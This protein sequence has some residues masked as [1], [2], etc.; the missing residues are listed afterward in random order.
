MVGASADLPAARGRDGS[1]PSRLL[2]AAIFLPCLWLIVR[3]GDYHFVLLVDIILVT[4]VL[5]FY[6]LLRNKG[7]RPVRAVGVACVLILSW[8]AYFRAGVYSNFLLALAL[9]FLMTFELLRGSVE[10]AVVRIASTIFGVL[11]V[12][13]LGSHFILLREL[14]RLAGLDYEMGARFVFLAFLLTWSCD[15]GAYAIGRLF[16][17]HS[18]FPSVSPKKS[19]E[20]AL[21][22]I[23]FAVIAGWVAQV[24][25][26]DYLT[27]PMAVG[28]AVVAAVAGI[29]GDLVESLMKR[30]SQ[31]KDSGSFIPG[32]GGT[33]DRFDS[34]FFSIPL[35]YY[36]HKFFVI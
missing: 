9:L 13:W 10:E 29:T 11:Y 35:I 14:P 4:G 12:G 27:L 16:G 3:R 15:T 28:L 24:T 34:L 6:G 18:L 30:D 26:A 1:L 32:H 19:R 5:E 17:R 25:F 31:L 23:L 22:G 33:L 21:G 20:G 2:A 7:F 36:F 8:Y